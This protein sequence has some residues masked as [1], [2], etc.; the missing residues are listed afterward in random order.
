MPGPTTWTDSIC[1]S[2]CGSIVKHTS[3]NR[4]NTSFSVVKARGVLTVRLP[5]Q[6]PLFVAG[7][8]ALWRERAVCA[9]K[10][11]SAQLLWS[12]MAGGYWWILV[13]TGGMFQPYESYD[14]NIFTHRY[15]MMTPIDFF[16]FF[17]SSDRF[18]NHLIVRWQFSTWFSKWILRWPGFICA[19]ERSG[20]LYARL[21]RDFKE[22]VDRGDRAEQRLS[23]PG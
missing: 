3:F 22:R 4:F 15:M 23:W 2:I 9:E 20:E 14:A 18:F 8:L 12:T 10:V 1:P 6:F 21:A 13:D 19:G 16:V 11:W 17:I 7:T 5:E